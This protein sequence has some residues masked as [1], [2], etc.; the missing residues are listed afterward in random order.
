MRGGGNAGEVHGMSHERVNWAQ[1]GEGRWR[2][3]DGFVAG[4]VI[5]FVLGWGRRKM[6]PACG[7]LNDCQCS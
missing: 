6:V 1:G 4:E 7:D 2:R 3:G 5:G